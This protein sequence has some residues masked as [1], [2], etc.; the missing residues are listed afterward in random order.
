MAKFKA[1]H[2]DGKPGDWSMEE[3]ILAQADAEVYAESLAALAQNY[4]LL[5]AVIEGT[6]DAV[7]VKDRNGRYLMIN[8]A[9]ARMLGLAAKE[10]IGNDDAVLRCFQAR[11]RELSPA[12]LAVLEKYG[13]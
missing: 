7:Y 2:I 13:R 11:R 9:G 12:C 8:G 3:G 1:V 4:S 10:V 6:P 5:S